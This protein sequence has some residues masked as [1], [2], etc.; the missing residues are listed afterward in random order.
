M[1]F[2]KK[3]GLLGRDGLP[4]HYRHPRLHGRSCTYSGGNS[5][6]KTTR[7]LTLLLGVTYKSVEIAGF[8]NC[9]L[10]T[11]AVRKSIVGDFLLVCYVRHRGDNSNVVCVL[12]LLS[13]LL[14]AHHF[15]L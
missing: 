13:R 3:W 8:R 12:C 6:S 2:S 14:K 7:W 5:V 15:H 10:V 11:N 4:D 9:G 1:L